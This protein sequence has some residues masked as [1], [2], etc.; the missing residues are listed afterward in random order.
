MEHTAPPEMDHE[1]PATLLTQRIVDAAVQATDLT[2]LLGRF[3][4]ILRKSGISLSRISLQ[5]PAL[6]PE[7][8]VQMLVWRPAQRPFE[9]KEGTV[10][11]GV[12]ES[13]TD[14][15]VIDV[16]ELA[17]DAYGTEAFR[18]SPIRQILLEGVDEVLCPID[19]HATSWAYPIL[20]DLAADGATGYAAFHVP[21]SGRRGA[22]SFA[23]RMPGGFPESILRSFRTALP[24]LGLGMERHALQRV[25]EVLLATYVGKHA[26]RQILGGRIRRGDV[27]RLSA[28]IWFSDLR[29]FTRLTELVGAATMVGWLNAYFE[30]ITQAI[31]DHGGEVLKFIG[32]A[33]LAVF[34]SV[35]LGEDGA[36]RQAVAASQ[37][38]NQAL[39]ALNLRRCAEGLPALAHGIGLHLGDVL[40]GNVGAPR[41]L[42]FTVVGPAVNT[43]ARI[44]SL[45]AG[46]GRRL[47]MSRAV[48][49]RLEVDAI[50]LGVFEVKGV[51]E[52][53][54][55]FGL[56]QD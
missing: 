26:G 19:Q 29:G 15:G 53:V 32:D 35:S 38:A 37:A 4:R 5:Q 9:L 1:L 40:F 42:D 44:E 27:D 48:R 16:I 33:A 52:A 56:P 6:H 39:D 34:P 7:V 54:E 20:Q 55:V 11:L 41:R 3:A 30:V 10:I 36:C 12:L 49:S 21:L 18:L 8:A 43:T 45:A 24:A 25:A 50:A 31:E 17:Y 13:A 2:D 51:A 47:L 23:T 28:A 14:D 46:L 22:C